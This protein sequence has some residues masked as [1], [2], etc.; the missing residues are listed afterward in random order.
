MCTEEEQMIVDIVAKEVAVAY[1]KGVMDALKV[2]Q[3][4]IDKYATDTLI[5]ENLR[6]SVLNVYCKLCS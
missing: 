6:A 1:E 3:V 4:V 2:M 5:R